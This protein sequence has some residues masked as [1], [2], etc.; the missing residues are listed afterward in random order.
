MFE[1]FNY[2]WLGLEADNLKEAYK[3]Y[4]SDTTVYEPGSLK[5]KACGERP[6]T[7]ITKEMVKLPKYC[8]FLF[9]RFDY[10]RNCKNNKKISYPKILQLSDSY[11]DDMNYELRSITIHSGGLYGG[12]YTAVAK[13]K[14]KWMSLNDSFINEIKS[15]QAMGKQ[16]YILFYRRVSD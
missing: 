3:N 15:K 16:A 8:I 7:V 4:I 2:V 6:E 12:H 9:N 1:N 13:K 5:C 10:I 11:K 14:N